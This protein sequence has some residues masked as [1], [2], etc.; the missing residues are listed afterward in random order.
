M[1]GEPVSDR[2]HWAL[3]CKEC[4][5]RWPDD[6]PMEAV[7]LHMQVEH[8]TDEV[9]LD[10]VPVCS[11]NTTMK[12]TRQEMKGEMQHSYFDC[13]SCHRSALIKNKP[14]A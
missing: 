1:A 7:K 6:A 11:C 13:P 14:P 9:N 2:W 4:R 8:D 3:E 10:L 12:L 5:C